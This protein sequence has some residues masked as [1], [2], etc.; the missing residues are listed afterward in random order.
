[1]NDPEQMLSVLEGAHNYRPS[2]VATAH[3]VHR[4][5]ALT[6]DIRAE[7]IR[8]SRSGS[9]LSQI[10]TISFERSN[11]VPGYIGMSVVPGRMVVYT[12]FHQNGLNLLRN[13]P[14]SSQLIFS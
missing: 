6:P 12:K 5:T 9:T 3:P 4:T 14:S 10:L 13:S 11:V 7:I 1:M 2:A 8:L